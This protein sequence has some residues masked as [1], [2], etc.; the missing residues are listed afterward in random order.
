MSVREGVS[1][2]G[3]TKGVE[4]AAYGYLGVA[5]AVVGELPAAVASMIVPSANT[6]NLASLLRKLAEDAEVT[7]SS[8]GDRQFIAIDGP[9]FRWWSALIDA[10]FPDVGKFIPAQ[11]TT[12]TVPREPFMAACQRCHA[13]RGEQAVYV[14]LAIDGS[15]A[16]TQEYREGL[17]ETGI[18]VSSPST[19]HGRAQ[20]AISTMMYGLIPTVH[21]DYKLLSAAVQACATDE[22]VLGFTDHK[23][24]VTVRPVAGENFVAMIAPLVRN[25]EAG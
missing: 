10:T 11:T 16:Y 2:R 15:R 1:V 20:E 4:V 5:Q 24:I 6:G 18:I 23:S 21:L 9:N 22:I 12:M 25:G 3:S 7:V 14:T 17:S 19:D 8:G 13:F